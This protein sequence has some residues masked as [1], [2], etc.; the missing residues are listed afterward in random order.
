MRWSMTT[1]ALAATTFAAAACSGGTDQAPPVAGAIVAVSG[2]AQTDTVA[3]TLA[4]PL[5]V[6]VSDQ[7][8]NALPGAT[9]TWAAI[10][11]GVVSS[12]STTTDAT[13]QS[14]VTWTIGATPGPESATATVASLAPVTFHATATVGAASWIGHSGDGQTAPAG[15]AVAGP[16]LV[17]IRDRLG[18]GIP[19]ITVTWTVDSG[20][21]SLSA[22]TVT[23]DASGQAQVTWTLGSAGAQTVTARANALSFTFSATAT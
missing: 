3:A 13:G 5:V 8:G 22:S 4:S 23:T 17:V 21:G 15:T 12:S 7:Q 1:V 14:S 19:G 18:N 20:G 9:V 6:K 16:L 11:G 2:D 10:G